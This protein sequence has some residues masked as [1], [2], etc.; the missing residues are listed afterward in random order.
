MDVD[1]VAAAD[2]SITSKA[3][4]RGLKL[5]GGTRTRASSLKA[6]QSSPGTDLVTL[7]SGDEAITLQWRGGLPTPKLD[8]PRA[9]HADAV[10]GADVVVEATRTGFE[11]FVGVKAKPE[12]GFS[13]G[14][15]TGSACPLQ[16][17]EVWS[18]GAVS[19]SSRWAVPNPPAW[20]ANPTVT[21]STAPS[22][23]STPPPAPRS[24][25][26]WCRPTCRPA[27]PRR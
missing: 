9:T 5:V 7:G 11:Q 6:A 14:N 10:S 20:I 21:R 4:P 23:S 15:Y 17:W 16:P 13:S 1:L 24:A 22:R 12:A 26:S 3:H 8:G 2:G 18:T 25:T 19:T 27:S